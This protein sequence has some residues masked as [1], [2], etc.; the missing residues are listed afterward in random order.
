MKTPAWG[1]EIPHAS[2]F[3][4]RPCFPF[5]RLSPWWDASHR[6]LEA[7]RGMARLGFPCQ[8]RRAK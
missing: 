4:F 7:E 2:P 6:I 3:A 8:I 1:T 5:R